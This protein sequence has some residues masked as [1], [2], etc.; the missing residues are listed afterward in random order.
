MGE[1]GRALATN[2]VASSLILF[3][4]LIGA[5]LLSKISVL[6][7]ATRCHIYKTTFFMFGFVV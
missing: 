1:I 7:R 5:I 3:T 4:L 2:V 6:T